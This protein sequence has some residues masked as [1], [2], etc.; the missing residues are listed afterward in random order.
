MKWHAPL[1]AKYALLLVCLILGAGTVHGEVLFHD[2]FESDPSDWVCAD[3]QLS[4]WSAGYLSC[5]QTAG[6]GFEWKMGPGRNS[7]NAVY[8]WKSSSVPNGYRTESQKWLTGTTVK[9][10]IY[11]RW[12]MKWPEGL[13]KDISQGFKL[14]RYI[15]RENGF[16]SPPEIYLNIRPNASLSHSSLTIY[17]PASGYKDLIAVSEFNDD[18][19]HCHELRIKLNSDGVSDGMLQYWLDGELV[20]TYSNLSFSDS[21]T[22]LGIHRFGVGISNVSDPPWLNDEWLAIAFDDVVI[23]TDYI[24]PDGSIGGPP[25]R[26]GGL[27]VE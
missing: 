7:N 22:G 17:N 23:S 2:D 18:A 21:V 9:K 25:A 12:Y 15:L 26:P 16:S 14:W 20:A 4:Q 3:G 24:D 19:W 1:A 6:F 27:S 5:K 11:H 8:A 13:E 10:E